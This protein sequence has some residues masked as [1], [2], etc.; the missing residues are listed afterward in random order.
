MNVTP[1]PFPHQIF[2][3]D[4]IYVFCEKIKAPWK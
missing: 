1:P 4:I 3:N 2:V